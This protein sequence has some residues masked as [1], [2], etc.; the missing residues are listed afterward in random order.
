MYQA[1][2]KKSENRFYGFLHSL[3]GN[4][5]QSL[6][7]EPTQDIFDIISGLE[8]RIRT[9]FEAFKEGN[10]DQNI[11]S[12]RAAEAKT[13]EVM[14]DYVD[15]IRKAQ[16]RHN[17]LR[18]Y[19]GER[20]RWFLS[21][22]QVVTVLGSLAFMYIAPKPINTIGAITCILGLTYPIFEY[23]LVEGGISGHGWRFKKA[24]M[25]SYQQNHDLT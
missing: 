17:Y 8:N 10:D 13:L 9:E 22:Q 18:I 6:W 1:T 5:E 11:D 20:E 12:L 2:V 3:L 23:V 21:W 19:G 24:I 14:R 15:V 4:I 7:E 16:V 25:E